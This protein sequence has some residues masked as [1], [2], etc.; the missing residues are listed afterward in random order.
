MAR[1]V[2]LFALPL[3]AACAALQSPRAGLSPTSFTEEPRFVLAVEKLVIDEESAAAASP[4]TFRIAGP[5]PADV[6]K[7]WARQRL[8]AEGERGLARLRILEASV[9]ETAAPASR[10]IG[11]YETSAEER[12]LMARLRVELVIEGDGERRRTLGEVTA[13]RRLRSIPSPAEIEAERDFLLAELARRFDNVMTAQT[14]ALLA[15]F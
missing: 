4:R 14:Q 2:L 9:T 11:G 8:V 13:E 3:L 12:A 7:G 5:G 1:L 10:E 6:A 15:G